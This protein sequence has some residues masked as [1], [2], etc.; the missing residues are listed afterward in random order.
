MIANEEQSSQEDHKIMIL[1]GFNE[2]FVEFLSDLQMVFPENLDIKAVKNSM[3]LMRKINKKSIIKHWYYSVVSKYKTEIENG[4][5]EFFISKDYGN[6][7]QN[8]EN[9]DKIIEGIN[10]IRVQI[11]NMKDED[12]EKS[13]KYIQNLSKLS[14]LYF[15]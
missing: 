2:H 14:M 8:A 13:M 15:E 9:S 1:S 3:T 11:Q 12:Q 10:R 5:L 7:L 4:D 6:D